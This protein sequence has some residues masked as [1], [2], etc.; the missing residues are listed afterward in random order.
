MRVLSIHYISK[1]SLFQSLTHNNRSD[2]NIHRDADLENPHVPYVIS[3]STNNNVI[4]EVFFSSEE[5]VIEEGM[6]EMFYLTTHSTHF[7]Y[8]RMTSDI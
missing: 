7:I 4:S 5:S 2:E 6:D 1:L 3:H 8:G